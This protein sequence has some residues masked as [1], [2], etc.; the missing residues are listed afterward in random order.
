MATSSAYGL[1]LMEFKDLE[2]HPDLSHALQESKDLNHLLYVN[3]E[4][5]QE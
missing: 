2:F 3:G 1:G 5:D 4:L